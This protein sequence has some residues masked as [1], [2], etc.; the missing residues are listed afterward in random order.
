MEGVG[1]RLAAVRRAVEWPTGSLLVVLSVAQFFSEQ[2]L[3]DVLH[4]AFVVLA[5]A[6][7]GY[8]AFIKAAPVLG[9][10]GA[11][12]QLY[13]GWPR[14]SGYTTLGGLLTLVVVLY[15]L[16]V[17]PVPDTTGSPVAAPP[18]PAGDAP[19]SPQP[20]P[21]LGDADFRYLSPPNGRS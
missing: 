18:P 1:H 19:A 14:S 5:V 7:I 2:V 16:Y 13:T 17:K 15:L 4:I 3:H 11:A 12:L 21:T 10:V 9:A 8:E 6:L 20:E